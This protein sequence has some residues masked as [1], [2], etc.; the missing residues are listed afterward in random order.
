MQECVSLGWG[1][2]GWWE[3][4][5]FSTTLDL[6]YSDATGS[7][8]KLSTPPALDHSEDVQV[9]KTIHLDSLLLPLSMARRC[10]TRPSQ[11]MV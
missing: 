2:V 9:I 3:L 7:V 1:G 6:L 8:I 10:V 11:R 4:L 5:W